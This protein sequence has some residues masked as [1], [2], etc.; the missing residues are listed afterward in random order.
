MGACLG[1]D[2]SQ[3]AI[4]PQGSR[5]QRLASFIQ[6]TP[7][8]AHRIESIAEA[9]KQFRAHGRQAILGVE[10]SKGG[11]LLE[12]A[13]DLVEA[14]LGGVERHL[15]D[16]I[17]DIEL[18][19]AEGPSEPGQ[20]IA[21]LTVDFADSPIIGE[22]A[23]RSRQ[24]C[25]LRLEETVTFAIQKPPAKFTSDEPLVLKVSGML[26]VPLA[27]IQQLREDMSKHFGQELNEKNAG[28]W[29]AKKKDILYSPERSKL[30]RVLESLPGA[31]LIPQ[32]L[33]QKASWGYTL[34]VSRVF[35]TFDFYAEGNGKVSISSRTTISDTSEQ[36]AA[37]ISTALCHEMLGM[38]RAVMERFAPSTLAVGAMLEGRNIGQKGASPEKIVKLFSAAKHWGTGEKGWQASD[39][40]WQVVDTKDRW[41]R[42][43]EEQGRVLWQYAKNAKTGATPIRLPIPPSFTPET[44]LLASASKSERGYCHILLTTTALLLGL[45]GVLILLTDAEHAP[46]TR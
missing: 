27:D 32:V 35:D 25:E 23:T 8:N 4:K 17:T 7:R 5:L 39:K 20:E 3:K 43:V 19:F 42:P 46:R 10:G 2:R 1:A 16:A 37:E 6:G 28:D 40:T 15:P 38:H 41:G 9:L 26:L 30:R 44:T 13:C 34:A 36:W 31:F 11:P 14:V 18:V 24:P 29:W 45:C 22:F 33:M 12:T 21:T